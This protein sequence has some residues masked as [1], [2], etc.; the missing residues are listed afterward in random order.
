MKD[1]LY[2]TTDRTFEIVECKQCRLV[3]LEPRPTAAEIAS[4][5]PDRYWFTPDGLPGRLEE[6]YRRFV[7]RDHLSFARQALANSDGAGY[8]LDVGCGNG[9]LLSLLPYRKIVGLDSSRNAL[10]MAW[11]HNGAPGVCAD[12]T[13]APLPDGSCSVITMF[14][15][16]EHLSEP[17]KA[18]EAA[19]RL[20]TRGGRLVV[21]VPNA[22]CWQFMFF[23]ENWNGIDAPRHL[24]TYRQ[25]DIENLLE[26]SGFEVVRRKH[27]CLRDN[28]AG[29]ATSIAPGLDPMARRVRGIPEGALMRLLK[30]AG[31][32]GLVLACLPFTAIEA[33]CG[34]GSTVMLEARLKA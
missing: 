24:Y 18:L 21:Q 23:G 4:Y 33:A 25:R 30:D 1:R 20:L 32:L 15:V 10:S 13:H 9:L 6:T 26:F 3:R 17:V 16:L 28:P 11:R 8:V 29:M 19:R 12:L 7:L 27:F 31:Y 22:S 34:A 14:H 5:Y 2:H